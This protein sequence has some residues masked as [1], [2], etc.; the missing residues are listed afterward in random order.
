MASQNQDTWPEELS[1]VHLVGLRMKQC[2]QRH[3]YTPVKARTPTTLW[4]IT[5]VK[6]FFN[7][8]ISVEIQTLWIGVRGRKAVFGTIYW[9]PG[10]VD[11]P[12]TPD[13]STA[14]AHL[15][16]NLCSWKTSPHQTWLY[17][18]PSQK[19]K[20]SAFL[21]FR[22]PPYSTLVTL[23]MWAPIL[24]LP[25]FNILLGLT[26]LLLFLNCWLWYISDFW[27]KKT[28]SYIALNMV[29]I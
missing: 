14:P 2:T 11:S 9:A 5:D 23:I 8:K 27:C 24:A 21:S 4:K 6:D 25:K 28:V 7:H 29:A 22:T 1:I 10:Y 12:I 15:Y 18:I 16:K 13:A 26:L 19:R 3:S 17:L 20:A